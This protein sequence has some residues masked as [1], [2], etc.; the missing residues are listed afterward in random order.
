MNRKIVVAFTLIMLI[1]LVFLNAC[2]VSQ[3]KY[4]SKLDTQ[5]GKYTDNYNKIISTLDNEEVYSYTLEASEATIINF[6]KKNQLMPSEMEPKEDS[7]WDRPYY[8]YEYTKIGKDYKAKIKY[9]ETKKAEGGKPEYSDSQKK[10]SL[11]QDEKNIEYSYIAGIFTVKNSDGVIYTGLESE[12]NIEIEPPFSNIGYGDILR[13]L[14]NDINRS[15]TTSITMR[16]WFSETVAVLVEY[17]VLEEELVNPYRNSA[18]ATGYSEDLQFKWESI[19]G[20]MYQT[21]SYTSKKNKLTFFEFHKELYSSN[22]KES[23]VVWSNQ[24]ETKWQGNLTSKSSYTVNIKY[25]T[26]KSPIVFD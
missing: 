1:L 10:N 8:Q 17:Y 25:P 19:K 11:Y 16:K 20:T 23:F 21:Y 12:F 7:L 26:S 13:R 3:E 9:F 5:G 18:F 24:N 2:T 6:D 4:E 15:A 14:C 22:K